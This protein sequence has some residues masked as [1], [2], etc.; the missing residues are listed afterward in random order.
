MVN[1]FYWIKTKPTRLSLPPIAV[2]RT[3]SN[4]THRMHLDQSRSTGDARTGSDVVLNIS[5]ADR[6]RDHERLLGFF[7][8]KRK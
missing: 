6:L 4:R 7:E 2:R 1:I 5:N 8:R 3:V